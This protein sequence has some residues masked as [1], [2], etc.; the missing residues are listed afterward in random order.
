M[1]KTKVLFLHSP[2]AALGLLA[3]VSL[4]GVLNLLPLGQRQEPPAAIV[5]GAHEHWVHCLA[6]APDGKTLAA[7]GG[8]VLPEYKGGVS[9]WDV[10]TCRPQAKLRGHENLVYL[11][12]FAPGGRTVATVSF[13][14][15]AKLWEVATG[16]ERARI[17]LPPESTSL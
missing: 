15:V 10:P 3:A 1:G 13:D 2:T 8:D 6:F 11:A 16:R 4:L 5:L 12:A 17:T 7:G 14:G 9:L